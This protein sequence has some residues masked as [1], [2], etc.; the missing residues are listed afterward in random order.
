M[1]ARVAFDNFCQLSTT[2]TSDFSASVHLSI[3]VAMKLLSVW[4]SS[5]SGSNCG[6]FILLVVNVDT[7]AEDI[8]LDHSLSHRYMKSSADF[9]RSSSDFL[10]LSQL[11]MA[12]HFFSDC[13]I[14]SAS[15]GVWY[16]CVSS[17]YP[18]RRLTATFS[19]Q[20][21]LPYK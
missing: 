9:R 8:S 11:K 2:F 6:L 14:L 10:M 1:P 17:V 21:V 20:N 5:V 4:I 15:D 12:Q 19:D 3:S 16:T 13:P 18:Y 7:A